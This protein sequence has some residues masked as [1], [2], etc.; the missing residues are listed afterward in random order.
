MCELM[1]KTA[2]TS[3]MP[4]AELRNA[5]K[6][7]GAVI[8]ADNINLAI[9]RG[10]FLSFLG[11]SGCGKTTALRMLAGFDAP[12][13]GDV[14]LDGQRVNDLPP[15][16]RP[17][18]MVFQHYALFPHL[19]VDENISYG[20]R[21]QRP[22]LAASEIA[23]SV[24]AALETVRLPGFGD[25]R[26]WEMSGGQQQRVALARA[27]INKPKL[28]L[29]DEP[30]AALDKKLRRDMQIELQSLQRS[31]G[32]TFVL[33]THD[34]EEALSMSDRIC[35][36][37][38]GRIVQVGSPRDL[39]DRPMNKYVADF[40]G[41]S[42]FFPGIVE[43]VSG[44]ECRIKAA[45]GR[46]IVGTA[47]QKLSLGQSCTASLRPEQIGL[48][49]KPG[50][51]VSLEVKI[52]ALIFLGEHTEYLVRHASLGDFL[53]LL[54]RSAEAREGGF[55]VGASAYANWPNGAALI[56]AND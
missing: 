49:R 53:V 34:Q 43:T 7:F 6:H 35:I 2:A 33:V 50:S 24:E 26:I 28:L 52:V 29:L 8:A 21:Q 45:D 55:E 19:T 32:I 46:L 47:S 25:R 11:P 44:A 5:S 37:R 1:Q 42:N 40:V 56:L 9:R 14:F 10:E 27:I 31:L 39:Y 36:M 54:S 41:K 20:L 3:D 4:I 13:S 30:M 38:G 51:D 23:Q 16:R 48:S 17:V 15:H 18:N 22:R 12:T